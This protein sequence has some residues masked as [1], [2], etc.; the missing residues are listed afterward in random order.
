MNEYVR[1]SCVEGIIK[2]SEKI[3]DKN[4]QI[5]KLLPL[6]LKSLKD[7]NWRIRKM[8]LEKIPRIFK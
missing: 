8:Y 2:L 6:I 4:E 7:K 5:D 1:N 3:T